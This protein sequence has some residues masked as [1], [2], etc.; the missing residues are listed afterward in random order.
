MNHIKGL[1]FFWFGLLFFML[2]LSATS[3]FIELS[4][5]TSGGTGFEKSF[6]SLALQNTVYT[7]HAQLFTGFHYTLGQIDLTTQARWWFVNT[8]S[9]SLGIGAQYHSGW[10]LDYGKEHDVFASICG[11]F[12][13]V[14]R[15]NL[16]LDASYV[17]KFSV[18]PSIRP[19]VRYLQD[20]GIAFI[21]KMQKEFVQQF[22]TYAGVSSYEAYRYPLFL[23]PIYFV[24][25]LYSHPAGLTLRTQ[26]DVRYS[27]QFTITSYI[28]HVCIRAVLGW[29]F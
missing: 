6:V 12:G 11:S 20:N 1:C 9:L 5:G 7:K 29:R 26:L 18:V 28:T 2:P 27:D 4:V 17:T 8:E 25:V 22:L 14:K 16:L 15:F 3:D 10:F 23:T 19:N 13:S 24:G 21:I